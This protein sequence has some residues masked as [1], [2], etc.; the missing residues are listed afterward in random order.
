[1]GGGD[2]PPRNAP[3]YNKRK[4]DVNSLC[5]SPQSQR[6]VIQNSHL[7]DLVVGG[8]SPPTK[9]VFYKNIE[10]NYQI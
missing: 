9:N 4:F 3:V 7:A 10:K 5:E 1:M 2:T 6:K 8:C